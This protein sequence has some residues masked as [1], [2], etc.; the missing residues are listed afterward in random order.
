MKKMKFALIF[1]L[2]IFLSSCSGF[3]YPVK[4]RVDKVIATMAE[5]ECYTLFYVFFYRDTEIQ[6]ETGYV[7][8]QIS[9]TYDQVNKIRFFEFPGD[10]SSN[11]YVHEIESY[12]EVYRLHGSV[13]VLVVIPLNDSNDQENEFLDFIFSSMNKDGKTYFDQTLAGI[14][15]ISVEVQYDDMISTMEIEWFNLD[16][17]IGHLTIEEDEDVSI[18]AHYNDGVNSCFY[19]YGISII[20]PTSSNSDSKEYLIDLSATIYGVPLLELPTVE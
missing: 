8:H 5:V 20:T 18:S 12:L 19:W 11:F 14:T 1:I 6:G 9:I 16:D 10:S 7:T 15:Y 4:D 3:G 17:S 13:W 2:L